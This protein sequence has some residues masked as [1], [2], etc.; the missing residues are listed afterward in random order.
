VLKYPIANG[1]V[2]ITSGFQTKERPEHNGIDLAPVPRGTK[3]QIYC[4]ADGIVYLLKYNS[5]S[6]GNYIE[7]LHNNGYI[8]RYLHL[9]LI[10]PLK[11]DAL[12][13]KGDLIGIMGSTGNSTGIHLHF[14]IRTVKEQVYDKSIDPLP[15]LEGFKNFD[16][17]VY[18]PPTTINDYQWAIQQF[19]NFSNPIG[20]WKYVDMHP[21]R[22]EW[23]KLWWESY[24]KLQR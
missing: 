22:E 7:I 13:K 6:A 10:A 24:E 18:K 3:L 16:V 17:I 4:I 12:I 1:F 21:N 14:E 20:I 23:Y 15:Y 9:D 8:S 11:P 2:E 19:C 5:T